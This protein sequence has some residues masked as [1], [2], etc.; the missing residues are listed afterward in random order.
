MIDLLGFILENLWI[1]NDKTFPITKQA[2]A[3]FNYLLALNTLLHMYFYVAQNT[4][5][6]YFNFTCSGKYIFYFWKV[7]S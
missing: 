4:L 5:H 6:M 3:P 7:N 2:K 1:A